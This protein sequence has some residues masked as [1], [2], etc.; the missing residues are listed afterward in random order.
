MILLG[1]NGGFGNADC[2]RLPRTAID[3]RRRL[4]DFPRLKSGVP[5][6]VPLCLETTEAL[7][8]ALAD[9]PEPSSSEAPPLVFLTTFGRPWVRQSVATKG[10]RTDA[11]GQEF[12]KLLRKL[13]LKRKGLGF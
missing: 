12:S 11:M 5:G 6:V 13:G 2:G 4:I 9:R 8:K 3:F 10:T 1:I 7:Q